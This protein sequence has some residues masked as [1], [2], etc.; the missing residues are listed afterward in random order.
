[1]RASDMR[2]SETPLLK[3]LDG[4]KQFTVP[5][6]Q[7]RYSWNKAECDQLWEDIL[8]VGQKEETPSHFFGSIVS[9]VSTED[10]NPRVP[11]IRVIDGQ[12][13]LAT[14]A[15]L[16]SAL[17]RTIERRNVEIGIDRSQLE[18][19]YLFNERESGELRYK[20]LL[21][22][23]D[24]QTFIELLEEGEAEDR[25]SRLVL[26]YQFFERELKDADLQ[27]VYKGI[28]RLLIVDISL[29]SRSG[30]PQ[31]IFESLNSTGRPLREADKIR[32]YVIME[33]EPH[34]QDRLY[35]NYW[36]PMEQS[37]GTLYDKRFDLFI[38][39]Y[40]TLKTGQFLKK[41]DV[42]KTFKKYVTCQTE[43]VS[44]EEVIKEI[45]DYSKHYLHIILP[46]KWETD[47]ELLACLRDIYTLKAE[48]VFPVLLHFYEGY[49]Q[50]QIKKADVIESFRLIE[51][52]IF[53][54]VICGVPT[55]SMNRNFASIAGRLSSKY[56]DPKVLSDSFSFMR[57]T[58]RFP[59]DG[60]FKREFLIKD[61][62]SLRN[63]KYLLGKLENY[64]REQ[65]IHDVDNYTIE[66]VMPHELSREWRAELG[67]NYGEVHETYLHT[68]GNL[69][70]TGHNAELSNRPFK[71]KQEIY[72]DFH[73]RQLQLNASLREVERWNE[74][75]IEN[76]A[77]MFLEMALKIWSDHGVDRKGQQEQGQG[78]TLV[79]N[80]GH[81]TRLQVTMP[82]GETIDHRSAIQTFCEVIERLGIDQV[83]SVYPDL[84]SSVQSSRH[85]YKVGQY[86]IKDQTNT[87]A[88]KRMLDTIAIGLRKPLKISIVEK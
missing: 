69:T 68:I 47:P 36:Y 27:T 50:E 11:S 13:R 79:D 73:H 52:Y 29:D 61:V 78:W 44:L 65:P 21:T 14:L 20:Q 88:K 23:H 55:A 19:Y 70:L 49:T 66:H 75:A 16:L 67:D 15:L 74:T 64:G 76:R 10:G 51:S 72:G 26:N 31:Q 5:I 6:F 12:Q 22:Q 34:L 87:E 60:E 80:K 84:I 41:G 25:H 43:L 30:N 39:D 7:R 3:Y 59:S 18:G 77:K 1:M 8:G 35:E 32:N 37:F 4:T 53:R 42:Y 57:G 48:V 82:D 81:P 2:A 28:Q 56:D 63:C 17:G 85:G 62:Y 40:L 71:E 33:Q 24:R 46:W 83:S 45:V 58:H 38:R 54:R 86:Y 9:T